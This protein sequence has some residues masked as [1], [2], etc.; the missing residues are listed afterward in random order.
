MDAF[1]VIAAPFKLRMS[2]QAGLNAAVTATSI[3]ALTTLGSML[4]QSVVMYWSGLSNA[5]GYVWFSPMFD[6][7]SC[8]QLAEIRR[9]S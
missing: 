6:K 4:A 3:S 1:D 7:F 8:I 9:G 2:S 5:N